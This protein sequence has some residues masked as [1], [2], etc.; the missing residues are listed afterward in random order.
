M[1]RHLAAAA[2]AVAFCLVLS[3]CAADNAPAE[4][5][6]PVGIDYVIWD[7][8]ALKPYKEIIAAFAK[9]R[10]DITVNIQALPWEQYWTKLQTQAS[11]KSLPDVFWVN[12]PNAALYAAN[13][14]LEPITSLPA[15][16]FPRGLI[17]SYTSGGKLYASP[18]EIGTMG[19]W[20]N[21][22]LFDKAGVAHPRKGWTQADFL[23]AART[24][25]KKLDV[26]GAAA[27]PWTGQE[28]YYNT[29]YQSGGEVVSADKRRS[30][31]D[32]PETIAGIKLWV[33]LAKE[34]VS[35]SVQ[36]ITDTPVPQYFTSG[37][38][39][40]MWSGP[41]NVNTLKDAKLAGDFAVA[42]MPKGSSGLVTT[43][44]GGADAVSAQSEH[45]EAAQAFQAFLGSK[46]AQELF[47][48][49]GLGIPAFNGS[50]G[51]FTA[52]FP[53][54]DLTFFAEQA[55]NAAP[56]PASISAEAWNKLENEYLTKAWRGELS[57]EEACKQLAAAMN[58]VLAAEPK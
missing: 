46:T 17:D 38:L 5:K 44:Q 9:Q 43:V 4:K 53:Q 29:I 58:D 31:Y 30:G 42:P 27:A 26:F 47:G 22:R 33:D 51:S 12:E 57:V 15:E 11:S 49:A 23:D 45:K 1:N 34:G 52:A 7:A 37:K 56:Y 3:G 6:G 24:I 32:R 55:A 10:P 21:K 20:Y 2:A 25:S 54:W 48:A 16:N 28:T 50:S 36:Q 8:N 19:V 14:A 13:G 18:R 40:M 39:A 41:W 35:P